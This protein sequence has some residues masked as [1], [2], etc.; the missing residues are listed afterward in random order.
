VF[1]LVA[2]FKAGMAGREHLARFQDEAAQYAA[3]VKSRL[4]GGVAVAVAVV[5]AG[6]GDDPGDWATTVPARGRAF[7]V[8]VDLGAGRVTCPPAPEE[9]RR[10][11]ERHVG[12]PSVRS[13]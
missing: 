11:A 3:T 9:L 4:A 2:V 10:L 12:G 8:Y 7:P 1:V 6:G 5:E 13:V